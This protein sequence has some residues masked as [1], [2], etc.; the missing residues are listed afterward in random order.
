MSNCI[1]TNS[2]VLKYN[3]NSYTYYVRFSKKKSCITVELDNEFIIY[4]YKVNKHH[5]FYDAFCYRTKLILHQ[6]R[7]SKKELLDVLQCDFDNW[8]IWH[9][10]NFVENC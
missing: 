2:F 1:S 8:S 6:T 3:N 7:S 5:Y 4:L 9:F 10:D